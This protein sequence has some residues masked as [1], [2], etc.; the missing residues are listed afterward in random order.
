M[1]MFMLFLVRMMLLRVKVEWCVL[2]GVCV[3]ACVRV[4]DYFRFW[5]LARWSAVWVSDG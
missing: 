1:H 3:R 5:D 4:D 2:D